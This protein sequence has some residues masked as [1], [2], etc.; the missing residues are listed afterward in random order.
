MPEFVL[1]P[2]RRFF[3]ARSQ[4]AALFVSFAI[5]VLAPSMAAAAAAD[6]KRVVIG[7][8]SDA[9]LY[10]GLGQ[11]ICKVVA[12]QTS[13]I[14]CSAQT[15][16]GSVDNVRGL[17]DGRFDIAIVQS[18]VHQHAVKGQAM[19]QKSGPNPDL[20]SLF[21]AYQESLAV[22]VREDSGINGM[23]DF[24]GTRIN[25]GPNGSGSNTT[26]KVLLGMRGWKP[27]IFKQITTLE[28]REEAKSF[29]LGKVDIFTYVIGHPS[30]LVKTILEKCPA[31]FVGI[32]GPVVDELVRRYPYYVRARIPAAAYP[33]LNH[34]VPSIGMY[35]TVMTTTRLEDAVAYQVMKAVFEQLTAIR[36][37]HDVFRFM[38]PVDMIT[39]PLTA[40]FHDGAQ[41]Y[42]RNTGRIR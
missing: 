13:S 5:L 22:I 21:S 1:F 8:G 14:D 25:I 27:S 24:P 40:P 26:M 7:T 31:R 33:D 34:D 30:A 20:R 36:K 15:S 28:P 17:A 9:G 39:G 16:A 12:Q 11:A 41:R 2:A 37:T 29:C 23:E 4:T 6:A 42:L 3:G 38:T 18:D 10:I 32:T 35:A 19:F